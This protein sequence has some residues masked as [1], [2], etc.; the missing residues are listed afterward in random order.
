MKKTG[1]RLALCAAALALT[2]LLSG[3]GNG[4]DSGPA[5]DPTPTLNPA[6]PDATTRLIKAVLDTSA[7]A[8]ALSRRARQA[9]SQV[10]SLSIP[11]QIT[12][13]IADA[14]SGEDRPKE[15]DGW[16]ALSRSTGGRYS[17]DKPY[18][19]VMA[20]TEADLYV[21]SDDGDPREVQDMI[22]YDPLAFVMSGEGGGDFVFAS[23]YMVRQDGQCA[24]TETVSRL[25]ESVSGWS[26]DAYLYEKGTLY[27]ADVQLI[28]AVNTDGE[29]PAGY[30]WRLCAGTVS[31]N[32]AD[33]REYELETE[34]LA[35][36]G[37]FQDIRTQGAA[38]VTALLNR[39]DSAASLTV[40]NGTLTIQNESGTRH[41]QM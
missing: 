40:E 23:Y 21:I 34:E 36:T 27:F 22:L 17:F 19:A 26:R 8:E 9:L 28:P 39:T 20:E 32:A 2:I 33:I 13:Q 4:Q 18:A 37:L 35:L 38:A 3:C 1:K 41:I 31:G 29:A 30:H 24:E 10:T 12:R 6:L 16:Y 25:N 7:S 5:P 11:G 15:T 14:F